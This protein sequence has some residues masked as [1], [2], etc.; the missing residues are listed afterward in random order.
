MNFLAWW[1]LIFELPIVAACLLSTVATLGAEAH[2]GHDHGAEGAGH[3]VEGHDSGSLP[4]ASAAAHP[5]HDAQHD[6]SSETGPGWLATVVAIPGGDRAPLSIVLVVLWLA[7][8]FIGLASNHL[9][10][11]LVPPIAFVWISFVLASAGGLLV[12]RSFARA[13]SRILPRAETYALGRDACVGLTAKVTTVLSG[14]DGYAQLY[15]AH[16]NLLEIRVQAAPA[17]KF[18]MGSQIV[19]V[20]Y[21]EANGRYVAEPFNPDG[22]TGSNGS[23]ESVESPDSSPAARAGERKK[24]K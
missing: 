17:A 16:R 4:V 6:D 10:A 14:S 24:V 11:R 9:F 21:D 13:F 20:S 22:A 1:N 2:G 5:D 23:I 19:L 8:G 15:D 18:E 7:F 3:D 12:S